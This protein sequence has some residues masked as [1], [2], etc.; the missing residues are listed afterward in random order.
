METN[1][2]LTFQRKPSSPGFQATSLWEIKFHFR[3]GHVLV[4]FFRTVSI[5]CRLLSH[6]AEHRGKGNNLLSCIECQPFH[7]HVLRALMHT[8]AKNIFPSHGK[9]SKDD[10]VLAWPALIC[11]CI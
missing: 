6:E 1:S 5:H 4:I 11:E 9:D 2:I 10:I 3:F 8:F 7:H